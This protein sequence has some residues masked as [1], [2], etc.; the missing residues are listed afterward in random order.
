MMLDDFVEPGIAHPFHNHQGAFD[1]AAADILQ[2]AIL[3]VRTGM[4]SWPVVA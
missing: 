2:P 3:S 1:P 4:S